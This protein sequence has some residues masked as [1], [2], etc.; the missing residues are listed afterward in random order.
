M[1]SCP[2]WWITPQKTLANS[3][4]HLKIINGKHSA[5]PLAY[6][7]LRIHHT[8]LRTNICA[9]KSNIFS[10]IIISNFDYIWFPWLSILTVDKENMNHRKF[11]NHNLRKQLAFS[12]ILDQS[13]KKQDLYTQILFHFI[14][15][16]LF[17]PVNFLQLAHT[18]SYC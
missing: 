1:G 3:F 6:V 8:V 5:F 9:L 11:Q 17:S 4:I 10:K 16:E 18:V 15:S 14:S 12:I 2:C 13:S 7:Y